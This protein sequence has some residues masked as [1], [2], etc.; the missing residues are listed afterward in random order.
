MKSTF[1][2]LVAFIASRS[3]A[4]PLY[5]TSIDTFTPSTV[6]VRQADS[7]LIISFGGYF[8]IGNM[9]LEKIGFHDPSGSH[10]WVV[11]KFDH[12]ACYSHG[13]DKK[14]FLLACHG[15]AVPTQ[16]EYGEET[17]NGSLGVSFSISNVSMVG[18]MGPVYRKAISIGVDRVN[19]DLLEEI[20][21]DE[22]RFYLKD[23]H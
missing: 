1:L 17:K 7:G 4:R 14:Q 15:D 10:A 2:I 11:M 9:A 5:C 21:R 13:D 6:Q 20:S 23:C 19:G 22:V 12:S 18:D 16:A 3:I 8:G